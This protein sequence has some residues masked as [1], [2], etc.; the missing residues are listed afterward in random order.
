MQA[1]RC[2]DCSVT[3]ESVEFGMGDTSNPHVRTGEKREGLL[4]MYADVDEAEADAY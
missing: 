4:R 3:M 2:P 1:K